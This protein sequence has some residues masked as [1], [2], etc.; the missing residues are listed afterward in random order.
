MRAFWM[1]RRGNATRLPDVQ[2]PCHRTHLLVGSTTKNRVFQL[3]LPKTRVP[4]PLL[5]KTP[6]KIRGTVSAW[7]NHHHKQIV[8]EVQQL[9]K[10]Y[11]AVQY[12]VTCTLTSAIGAFP[13]AQTGSTHLKKDR[14]EIE[15]LLFSPFQPSGPR[16]PSLFL[17]SF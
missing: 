8:Y 16:R 11:N 17:F 15:S 12:G 2:C 1:W 10:G 9:F 5:L 4:P 7:P 14:K 13:A 3:V 6:L